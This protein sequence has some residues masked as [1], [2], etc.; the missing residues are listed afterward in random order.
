[1]LKVEQNGI[2][3]KNELSDRAVSATIK[4]TTSVTA[5]SSSDRELEI[6]GASYSRDAASRSAYLTPYRRQ[7]SRFVVKTRKKQ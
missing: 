5:S 1:V 2:A 4:A 6:S 3:R 7:M